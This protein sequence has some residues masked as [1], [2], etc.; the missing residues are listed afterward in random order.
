MDE[1]VSFLATLH[2]EFKRSGGRESYHEYRE[3]QSPGSKSDSLFHDSAHHFPQIA[4]GP[5]GR[6]AIL[7]IHPAIAVCALQRMLESELDIGN[8]TLYIRRGEPQRSGCMRGAKGKAGKYLG[9]FEPMHMALGR[10][11]GGM[12]PSE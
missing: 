1:E 4:R 5:R 8:W 7:R 6:Y 11:E 12:C 3:S 9:D 10:I 2:M